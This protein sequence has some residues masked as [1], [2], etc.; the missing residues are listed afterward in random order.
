VMRFRVS[1]S[2][3]TGA[4]GA[5]TPS[6]PIAGG[7]DLLSH[8][9]G[10]SIHLYVTGARFALLTDTTTWAEADTAD[11][12][13]PFAHAHEAREETCVLIVQRIRPPARSQVRGCSR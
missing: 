9:A 10:L 4:Q 3:H 5:R 7:R 1:P 2:A 13:G 11:M 12:A 8:G 6:Q